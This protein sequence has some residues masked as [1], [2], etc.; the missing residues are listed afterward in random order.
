M[1]LPNG[2]VE[3][4]VI[5]TELI[6]LVKPY[7]RDLLDQSNKVLAF[8]TFYIIY[9]PAYNIFRNHVIQKNKALV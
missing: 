6:N 2:S 3:S 8:F 9:F 4:S 1:A 5:I 7:I